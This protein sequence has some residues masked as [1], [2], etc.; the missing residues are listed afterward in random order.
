MSK[1]PI[2]NFSNQNFD[3][4]A[5]CCGEKESKDIKGGIRGRNSRTGRQYNNKKKTKKT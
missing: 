2:Q 5:I 4:Q 1:D 3:I